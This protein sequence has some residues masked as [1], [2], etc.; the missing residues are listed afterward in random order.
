[1]RF[2]SQANVVF[3]VE[4][5]LSVLSGSLLSVAMP[6]N[7]FREL[8]CSYPGKARVERKGVSCGIFFSLSETIG[9]STFAR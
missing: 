8:T 2:A 4:A 3:S 6:R 5:C 1:M 7:T 9:L